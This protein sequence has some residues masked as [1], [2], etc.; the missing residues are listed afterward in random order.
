MKGSA[1]ARTNAPGK[2]EPMK[3]AARP[4]VSFSYVR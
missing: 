3:Q 4:L 1:L 2:K